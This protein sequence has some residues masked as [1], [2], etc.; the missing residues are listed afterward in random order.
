MR[1][2]FLA[3]LLLSTIFVV[4]SQSPLSN[5]SADHCATKTTCSSCFKSGPC[6]WCTQKN[7]NHP[8]CFE[9]GSLSAQCDSYSVEESLSMATFKS[10]PLTDPDESSSDERMVRI[11]PQHMSLKY[12]VGN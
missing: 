3:I 9:L 11:S 5:H 8:R 10:S 4:D 7:Y 2:I 6:S 1:E 12:S